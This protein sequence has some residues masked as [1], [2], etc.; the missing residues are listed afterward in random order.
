MAGP[1]GTRLLKLE[2]DGQTVTAQVSRSVIT[3]GE[4]DSDFVT[5]ADA[6]AGGARQYNL[7]FTAVQNTATGTIWDKIWTAAGT[8]VTGTLMPY[9]NVAPSL[10]EP[11]Y[12]FTAVVTEPDGDLLGGEANAS[13]TARFTFEGVWPLTGKP[14]KVTA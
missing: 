9:G 5:F 4:A 1:L 6:A 8:E 3:S 11:H 10:T 13:T 14:T 12:D 7:E 2:I